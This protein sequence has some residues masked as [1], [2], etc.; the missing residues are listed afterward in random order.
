MTVVPLNIYIVNYENHCV[1]FCLLSLSLFVNRFF[2]VRLYESEFV[3]LVIRHLDFHVAIHFIVSLFLH[4]CWYLFISVDRYLTLCLCNLVF[5]KE[6]EL[7][8]QLCI[9]YYHLSEFNDVSPLHSFT[10]L[11]IL[12]LYHHL[13]YH[14]A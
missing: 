9:S 5:L 7:T 14:R 2:N 11:C 3:L 4:L 12:P 1:P 10:R 13:S 6:F 8:C